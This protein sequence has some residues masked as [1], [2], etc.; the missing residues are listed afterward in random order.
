MFVANHRSNLDTF[1]L[2]SC[3]PG[4][5]GLAKKSIYYNIFFAPFMMVI[6]FIPVSKGSIT[7][8]LR[9]LQSLKTRVLDLNR[10][11]LI[12]PETTRCPK[13]FM[14]IQKFTPSIFQ[15]A[16]D[17]QA[18]IVPIIIKGTDQTMGQGDLFLTPFQRM[19]IKMLPQ[20]S[21]NQFTDAKLFSEHVSGLIL[22]ELL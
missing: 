8:F 12:F 3:I 18:V 9:G 6:G 19:N 1:I 14:G 21:P 4:L 15:V 10:P 7:S 5:R 20:I 17:S 22:K 11:V 2:I 16:I 13:N